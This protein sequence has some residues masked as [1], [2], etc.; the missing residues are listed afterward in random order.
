M[1]R[2][3][4]GVKV[5]IDGDTSGLDRAL[6]SGE[7]SVSRFS[8]TS[9][10]AFG[11]A[12]T[13]GVALGT[14]AAVGIGVAVNR[15]SDLGEEIS[16]VGVVFRGAGDDVV[17]W[18]RK[19][20]DS[21]GISRREALAATGI[22]GNMLVP[23]GVARQ[24]A[25]DMSTAMV[26]LAGDM[27]SFNNADPS[28]VLDSLR[29]GLAGE[30]EP[31]RR[32]GVFL[33]AA[34]IKQEALNLGIAKEGAELTAAAKAQATYALILKDTKDAQGDAT[35]TGDE[36]AGGLRRTKAMADDVTASLGVMFIPPLRAGLAYVNREVLP[37]LQSVADQLARVWERDDLSPADKLEQSW[38]RIQ[39]TGF[40]D[41]AK[42]AIYQGITIAATNAPRVFVQALQEAP[43]P[44]KAVLSALVLSKLAPGIAL[45]GKALGKALGAGIPAA[46]TVGR[47]SLTAA[48]ATAGRPIP[49]LVTNPGFAGR[50]GPGGMIGPTGRRMPNVGGVPGGGLIPP[51]TVPGTPYAP[52]PAP[53]TMWRPGVTAAAGRAVP[54]A[55]A[56]LTV[57][58]LT[59]AGLSAAG[60]PQAGAL[61]AIAGGAATGATMGAAAGPM[62]MLV[63]GLAGATTMGL[64][65]GFR[66]FAGS[67]EVE[68]MEER[69][70][71]ATET[72]GDGLSDASRGRIE[73]TTRRREEHG[74]KTQQDRAIAGLIA[75][76]GVNLS[77]QAIAGRAQAD[78]SREDA[79]AR[80]AA[81]LARTQGLAVAQEYVRG[82]NSGSKNV[83]EANL[84]KDT[85][86]RFDA[87][88]DDGRKAGARTVIA[89]AQAAE[90]EGRVPKG[91][92]DRLVADLRKRYR[93]LET[94]LPRTAKEAMRQFDA[95]FNADRATKGAGRILK[96]LH[97][98]FDD[99]PRWTKTTMD[100]VGRQYAAAMEFLEK[101]SRKG[102]DTQKADAKRLQAELKA[103]WAKIVKANRD[104]GASFDT[105]KTAA[106]RLRLQLE[107]AASGAVSA[108]TTAA[109]S[110]ETSSAKLATDMEAAIRR[111][112]AAQ[113][114]ARGGGDGGGAATGGFTGWTP[115]D[116]TGRDPYLLRV[117]GNEAILNPAQQA[118]IPGGRDT[119]TR[120]FTRTGGAL[121]GF[122]S[123]GYVNPVPGGNWKY[124]PGA[125]THSR[126]ERGYVWQDDDAWDIMGSDG[127]PV[128]AGFDG[129]VTR[130]SPFNPDSRFWGH[131]LYLQ[132][133]PG[134]LFYKH[135]K[136]LSV[137]A[138][139]RVKAGDRLGVLGDGV[140]GGAH[141]HLGANPLGLLES[142]RSGR[143]VDGAAGGGGDGHGASDA[144]VEMTPRQQVLKAL[145]AAG[146]TGKT[147]G[148]IANRVLQSG[149]DRAGAVMATTG[150][151][152]GQVDRASTAARNAVRKSGGSP[153][154]IAEARE[155]EARAAEIRIL[156]KDR[157][158]ITQG[159]KEITKRFRAIEADERAVR[160][161][162]AKPKAK[163]EAFAR[164][165]QAKARL[166]QQ[167]ETLLAA[168]A[169]VDRQLV[170]L[171]DAATE[172]T[173]EYRP[174]AEGDTGLDP[175][176]EGDR[177]DA[178]LSAMALDDGLQDQRAELA[179]QEAAK[180]EGITNT[181]LISARG[182]QAVLER[183]RGEIQDMANQVQQRMDAI[184]TRVG[185]LWSTWNQLY[186]NL[187]KTSMRQP[188]LRDLIKREIQKVRDEI[189]QLDSER[190]ARR[191]QHRSL[192][193]QAAGLGFQLQALAER[194]VSM[195]KVE[196]STSSDASTATSAEV[197][198]A[199]REAGLANSFIRT[200]F[201]PGD[202]STGGRSAWEAA[203]G[204][205]N[206]ININALS[207]SDPRVLDELQ[208]NVAAA[209]WFAAPPLTKS[210]QTGL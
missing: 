21:I 182:Q 163:R 109:S 126:S 47:D 186:T 133:G 207:A 151:R 171:G 157:I 13:A 116:Y 46:S 36:L 14:A 61:S 40:P 11:L 205:L 177:F 168:Q 134:T 42:E 4:G 16:K 84:W 203:G 139:S 30:T 37:E 181:E 173:A 81:G 202:L 86:K 107:G 117:D 158:R 119:L 73:Q 58:G 55:M 52:L 179:G 129:V 152:T 56:G 172:A 113:R 74:R 38:D 18:S 210:T 167:R 110:I 201:G 106:G 156:R 71:K 150:D 50:G 153:E 190:D 118:L 26:T 193:E 45:A 77:Q 120:I 124:G 147:A 194:M 178:G 183:Q 93:V 57:A 154:A 60:V 25:A 95:A 162:K 43:W 17:Q 85:S 82:L 66:K 200:A 122:A 78:R 27:A 121:R 138:G 111:I 145:K 51:T 34:R 184:T 15:A 75:S 197:D 123:G 103:Q 206:I 125:G 49:V 198:S 195:P 176:T 199:R 90:S 142:L 130:T 189:D 88:T 9:S 33:D 97:D 101:K 102:T 79:A 28:E 44:A 10:R 72:F 41:A 89:W 170:D 208:R 160:K 108:W 76:P 169:S 68:R 70:R 65:T 64:V 62:G 96:S 31:L 39:A 143:A 140:N 136:S 188:K 99:A 20:A 12:A 67:G 8:R 132:G 149:A 32:F 35:R 2:G 1:A 100:N 83:T 164:V 180:A 63:G 192:E 48:A 98:E 104:L 92:A 128:V 87:L 196:T 80:R 3:R 127:T 161:S 131:G 185:Q 54:G 59:H 159:L 187:G 135:L 69:I 114:R 6:R 148:G 204:F 53:A 24:K 94:D 7:S 191:E 112:A 174:P 115:G 209:A 166:R 137:G 105:P 141:L 29:A 144:E 22:F 175:I 165:R 19:T 91:T 146:I 155:H 23:M 5:Y